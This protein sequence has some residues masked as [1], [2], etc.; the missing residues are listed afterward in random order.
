MCIT[1][2]YFRSHSLTPC[3]PK[4]KEIL[5]QKGPYQFKSYLSRDLPKLGDKNATGTAAANVPMRAMSHMPASES[6]SGFPVL[7]PIIRPL[8]FD[9][10]SCTEFWNE[11]VT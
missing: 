10:L 2:I 4:Q 6:A 11:S 9:S 3:L 8:S 1:Y 5:I 7:R